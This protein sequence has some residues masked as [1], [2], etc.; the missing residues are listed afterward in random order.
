MLNIKNEIKSAFLE[1]KTAVYISIIL[2]LGTLIA[3][4]VLQPYLQSIFDPVVDKLTEDVKN[5]VITL[6]FQTIFTNNILIVF[7]MFVL[8]I[9]FCFSGVILAYNG[10]F[11]GYYIAS[12]QNLFR[13]LLYIIPHGIF[14]FS[15][16][17]IA[18]ASGFVLF[19]FLFRLVYNIAKLAK[20]DFDY[21]ELEDKFYNLTFKDKL[22]YSLEKNYDK[23]KQSLVLLGV[24][25]ILM[26]I[27]GVIEVY[28]TV[29]IANFIL[30]IFG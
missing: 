12:S 24:A 30:S 9:F 5:G 1:N 8:G 2:L 18:T 27:A 26:A 11:V 21:I 7:R 15:S 13:V 16:C 10:F 28:L 22:V 14:E 3:G 25:V 29:P 20:P 23:L 19:H 4:Y 17:I 6:T